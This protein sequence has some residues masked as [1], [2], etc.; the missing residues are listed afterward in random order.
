MQG[1]REGEDDGEN[2]KGREWRKGGG[3]QSEKNGKWKGESGKGGGECVNTKE[4]EL[5][6]RDCRKDVHYNWG[7]KEEVFQ[8]FENIP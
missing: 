3:R 6:R 5:E 2:R 1:D 4:G 8:S 7:Q